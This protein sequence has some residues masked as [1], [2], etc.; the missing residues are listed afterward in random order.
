M[1]TLL[2]TSLTAGTNE[3]AKITK[4]KTKINGEHA[5]SISLA[6]G[7]KTSGSSS[8][9]CHLVNKTVIAIEH[10]EPTIAGNSAPTNF[11]AIT[12]GIAIPSPDINVIKPTPLIALML[13]SVKITKINGTSIT[14]IDNCNVTMKD[15]FS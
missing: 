2:S 11:A 6:F 13:P 12:W 5:L 15:S 9:S 4:I 14:K 1:V 3:E 7:R 8:S 10:N